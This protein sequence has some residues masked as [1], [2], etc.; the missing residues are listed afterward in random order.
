MDTVCFIMNDQEIYVGDYYKDEVKQVKFKEQD[1]WECNDVYDFKNLLEY[2]NY[3][4]NYN[5]FKNNRVIILYRTSKDYDIISQV[6]KK[7]SQCDSVEITKLETILKA[8]V[9][10]KYNNAQ[11]LDKL[12][13]FVQYENKLYEMIEC[14]GNKLLRRNETHM[15]EN[16]QEDCIKTITTDEV[17]KF[18]LSNKVYLKPMTNRKLIL[19]PVNIM[20]TC[21]NLKKYLETC[22]TEAKWIDNQIVRE[23]DVLFTYTQWT[24]TFLKGFK[25]QQKQILAPI[26]GQI[27]WM[28]T[29]SAEDIIEK[30]CVLG[31]IGS[32]DDTEEIIKKWIKE[33]NF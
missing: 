22:F 13:Q 15:L 11:E 33:L 12:V 32:T 30:N 17:T 1:G 8:L 24:K 4:L 21:K 10:E 23:G 2:L 20:P 19:A 14:N 3:P 9:E 29:T 26:D 6:Q 16:I 27:F 7:W 25:K 5:D 31:V 18:V 28:N